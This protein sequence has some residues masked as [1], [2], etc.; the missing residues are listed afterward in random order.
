M[1]LPLLGALAGAVGSW[2]GGQSQKKA[3]RKQQTRQ[4]AEQRRADSLNR[5]AVEDANTAAREA[6]ER[7]FRREN[8][9]AIQAANVAHQRSLEA[10]QRARAADAT[11]VQTL[12]NDARAAGIHPLAAMGVSYGGP[13][14]QA[15]QASTPS[16]G[17]PNV[18]AATTGV[19]DLGDAVGDGIGNIGISFLKDVQ[20][21]QLGAA[22]I[23]NVH[24]STANLISEARSRSI[25]S[26]ARLAGQSLMSGE[27][28]KHDKRTTDAQDASQRYGELG[29]WLFGAHNLFQDTNSMNINPP[30]RMGQEFGEWLR[31]FFR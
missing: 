29:D 30:A 8:A 11:K 13:V 9:A 22:Q 17:V 21:L 31:S 28:I 3:A 6:A 26:S 25:I 10:E 15:V 1:V 5:K 27:T 12:V 2:F 16:Y 19:P 23:Q 7:A 24:A 18:Q 14:A 4:I 20:D